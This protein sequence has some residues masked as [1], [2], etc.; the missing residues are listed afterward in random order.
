MVIGVDRPRATKYRGS[1]WTVTNLSNCTMGLGSTQP[2][3][4]MSTRTFP[5]RKGL[6][7]VGMT[8]SPPFVSQLS[9][10]CGNLDVSQPY[11]PSRPVKGIAWPL[12]S[13][14]RD[15][16]FGM[17]TIKICPYFLAIF[18]GLPSCYPAYNIVF[19]IF[20]LRVLIRL[21]LVAMFDSMFYVII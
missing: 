11:G 7:A 17:I 21:R 6:P 20:S 9:R 14:H 5:G 16:I 2:L 18:C 4:E 10:K 3:T 12:P 13:V 8:I 1:K 19:I 15:L